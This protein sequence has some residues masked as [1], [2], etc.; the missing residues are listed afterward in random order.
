MEANNRWFIAVTVV[1]ALLLAVMP[2]PYQWL[3]FRPAFTA[4]LVIFWVNYM[5]QSLGVG[6]AW[7]VGLLEDLVTG[8][9]VGS[10]ALALAVVAYFSLLTYQRTRA[11]NM[12]QQLMWVFILVGINQVLGNWVHSLAGKPVSG[13]T[14][15]WP[16]VTS[17]LLWP[18]I[19]PWM[20]GVAGRL[21]VK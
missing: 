6:F 16:A 4:L 12:G 20:S 10:Q 11:F 5:P 13:L 19:A 15:L 9:A 2:L 21:H 17:A 7:A 3:W 18:W 1:V 8:A 14:F